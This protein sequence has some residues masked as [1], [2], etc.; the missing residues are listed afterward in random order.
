[1]N[2]LFIVN[3][4]NYGGGEKVRN[5]LA[6]SLLK[7]GH[8]VFYAIPEINENC[9]RDIKN[10][11]L[12]KITLLYSGKHLK[13][14]H[15]LFNYLIFWKKLLKKYDINLFIAFGGALLEQIVARI[16]NISVL[17]SERQ[18]PFSR[19]LVGKFIK[20]LEVYFS[21]IQIYQ[22][23]MA[24]KFYNNSN[25]KIIL[26]PI[27]DDL[28]I[29]KIK[30]NR[31]EIITVG[32]LSKEKNIKGVI[33]AFAEISK[34][35]PE[36]YL[37]IYGSGP[38]KPALDLIIQK[39]KL[40]NQVSIVT[41]EKEVVNLIN[42]ASLFILNSF[43]EGMPNALIE[44]MSVGLICISTNCP[45]GGPEILIK[46][47]FNGYLIPVGNYMYLADT[48]RFALNNKNSLTIRQNALR[49][50]DLL[51]EKTI[52]K[53]WENIMLKEYIS[54]FKIDTNEF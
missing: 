32:R 34:E 38:E 1:M 37:K 14:Y 17:F 30:K 11:N 16:C 35:Y 46:N 6:K 33:K 3:R 18:N 54:D 8:K 19:N 51:D 36:Y 47:N 45:I 10:Q 50:R 25:P 31:N 48:M 15:L 41:N 28:P 27:I 4:I 42:G 49:I 2:I 43:S 7:S 20:R 29:P 26:N 22:T 24:E 40:Q 23:S 9:K 39:E 21:T 13:K 53:Q 12:D 5:W 44:A 52:Y